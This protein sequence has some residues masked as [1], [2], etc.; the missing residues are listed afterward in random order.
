MNPGY[1]TPIFPTTYFILNDGGYSQTMTVDAHK[2]TLGFETEVKQ[3]LHL[4][5][6]SLY[7]NKEIFL[8]ELVSNA[9]D[10]CDKLRFE[11][12]SDD[13]LYEGDNE[14]KIHV[15]FDKEARTVTIRDNGIGMSRDEV[16]ANLGTIAKSGTRAFLEQLTG[17]Q[18][19]DANLIGQFGVGFYS[20]FIVAD[21]VSVTTRRAGLTAEH[22]VRWESG[23]EGEY[24]LENVERPGRG[25]EIVLHLREGDEEFADGWRLR[26]IIRKYSDHITLPIVM[27]KEPAPGEEKAEEGEETVNKASALWARPKSDI[28][29]EEYKEFYK[30]VS[31]DWEEPLAWSHNKVEGKLEYTS[32]LY[33]PKNAP[34]DLWDRER[35]NGIKLYVK[36]VFI[37]DDAEHLMPNY[38][39]F[40]RGVI[41]S[42]DLP[43]NVSREILQHNKITDTMRGASVKKVLGLLENIARNEPEKY[44]E[45]WK[46]FGKVMKEGPGEDFANREQIAGLLRFASTHNDTDEQNVSLADYIERM[47]EGQEAIYYITADS[48]AAAKNSPHLEIFRK[49]GIEVLLLHERVDEWLTSSLLEFDGKSLKS[50][51][52]GE[53]D[54]GE[55]EDEEE[56]KHQEEVAKDFEELVKQ[57]QET[58]G[59]KVKE[60]RISHRLTNSP[61]CLVTEEGEMSAN[62]ER[63]L[64]SV[65]QDAPSIKPIMELNPDHPLVGKLKGEEGE[66]FADLTNIL[67]DQALLAEGG[68]LDDPASFVAKLNKVLLELSA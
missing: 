46:Q 33:V 9:S 62:L 44:A 16:I 61:A 53:L 43:L 47:K 15:S 51:T 22:G 21:K 60:V 32:L 28:S 58:L 49:K 6:H 4:M 64:K 42:N 12:L 39:R 34:F 50:V 63:I 29:D 31:H 26:N 19:K 1:N 52:K 48:F 20:S 10:A 56:K 38:L 25:T 40:V 5:I 66:R 68:T 7:S 18:K 30:H 2:E 41:D 17:D 57:V 3:L 24:T 13:A 67:F 65:G 14:L 36:R 54:L 8:R 35:R 11:A 27:P 45:F 23:G 59:D 37:M 55:L